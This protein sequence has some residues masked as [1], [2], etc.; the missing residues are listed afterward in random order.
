MAFTPSLPV[1]IYVLAGV[2]IYSLSIAVYRVFFSP[3][4]KIP[5]P[6][7]AKLSYG[8]EFYYDVINRGS[9]IW[10]VKQMHERYGPVVRISPHEV[11]IQNAD[12]YDEVYSGSV[13][14]RNKW[15]FVCN[16]HGVPQSAFGTSSH[17]LHKMRRAALNP[18]FSKQKCRGLQPKIEQVVKNLLARF[19]EFSETKQPLPMSDAFAALTYGKITR[20]CVAVADYHPR[21]CLRVL[22]WTK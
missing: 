19:E 4:S 8:Y 14:K 12:F 6:L 20:H 10:Q 5:G 1:L 16:S 2:V 15:D 9:Y 11:H 7:L 13:R 3:I 18:F 22:F 21:C 17:E